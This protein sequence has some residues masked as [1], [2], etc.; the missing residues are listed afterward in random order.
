MTEAGEL[1]LFYDA[2]GSQVSETHIKENGLTLFYFEAQQLALLKLACMR[3]DTAAR[4]LLIFYGINN[5]TG[6]AELAESL[7]M[8]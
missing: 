4:T 8:C 7:S 1:R 5:N 2:C 6:N 3:T